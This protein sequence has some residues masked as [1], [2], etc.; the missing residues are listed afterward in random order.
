LVRVLEK[1]TLR[2]MEIIKGLPHV[3]SKHP[4]ARLAA[5]F[6]AAVGEEG[7]TS[8]THCISP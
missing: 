6:Y 1:S 5:F 3:D 4:A 8:A 7:R 2:K